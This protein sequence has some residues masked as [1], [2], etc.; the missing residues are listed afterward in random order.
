MSFTNAWSSADAWK[1]KVVITGM[2]QNWS[3]WNNIHSPPVTPIKFGHDNFYK[4]N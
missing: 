1:K 4:D 3:V 2:N